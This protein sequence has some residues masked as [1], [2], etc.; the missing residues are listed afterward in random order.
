MPETAFKNEDA[1]YEKILIQL[2]K[3]MKV[4]TQPHQNEYCTA[5]LQFLAPMIFTAMWIIASG[6]MFVVSLKVVREMLKTSTAKALS[7]LLTVLCV[8]A[9][10][11]HRT[12]F[13]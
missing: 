9:G 5:C 10:K 13:R 1:D 7:V 2:I 11:F 8:L 6:W 3:N 12:D 4:S